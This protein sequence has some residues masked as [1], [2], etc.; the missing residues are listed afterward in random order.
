MAKRSNH[1]TTFIVKGEDYFV[2]NLDNGGVRLGMVGG[3]YFDIPAGHA[4]FARLIE[5]N[6]E[7]EAKSYFDE[8]N[9][10]CFVGS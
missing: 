8:L 2:A 4:W 9:A 7:V 10:F 1:T 3:S 6:N 5:C